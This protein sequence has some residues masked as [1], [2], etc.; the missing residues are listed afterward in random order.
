M[1]N[2]VIFL[3]TEYGATLDADGFESTKQQNKVKC[4]ASMKTVTYKEYYEASRNGEEV[5]DIFVVSEQDY[6]LSMFKQ[7]N[8]KIKP[9]LIEYDGVLY[10]IVR[11]YRKSTNAD[12]VIE[13]TC[14]EV[15]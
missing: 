9:T 7:N 1:Q 4:F 15:E 13:L 12:Y 5:T 10:K 8:K 3:I 14:K 11:R 2:E 6:N